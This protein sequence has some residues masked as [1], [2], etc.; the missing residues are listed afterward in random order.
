MSKNQLHG[1]TYEDHLKSV[2][3]GS[4]DSARLPHSSWDIESKFDKDKGIPTSIKTVKNKGKISIDL[5]D[6]RKFWSIDR[7]Y[8][9]LVALYDQSNDVKNFHTLYEFHITKAEHQQLLGSVSFSEVES[10]HNILLSYKEGSHA[11]C[12]SFA[13]QKKAHLKNN[14]IVQLNP[15]IDS[16]TQRR[17]QC[18]IGLDNIR[19][20]VKTQ[21]VFYANDFYRGISVAFSIQ[22]SKRE[23]NK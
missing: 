11:E 1:K 23:F 4:S 13:K 10:F 16:K 19:A 18:S 6:A 9:M 2:F 7:D 17:L 22:S 21:N 15:K 14:S 5:A 3:P 12:R 20:I 8:R